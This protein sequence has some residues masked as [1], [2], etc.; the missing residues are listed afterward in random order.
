MFATGSCHR[1]A[2]WKVCRNGSLQN[3]TAEELVEACRPIEPVSSAFVS[4]VSSIWPINKI[5]WN[6]TQWHD[7]DETLAKIWLPFP[8]RFGFPAL[9]SATWNRLEFGPS[10]LPGTTRE[11]AT[12]GIV[13]KTQC[14]PALPGVDTWKKS[15]RKWTRYPPPYPLILIDVSMRHLFDT[16]ETKHIID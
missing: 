6:R 13:E 3:L 9:N 4:F 7:F 1:L 15:A 8:W 11:T 14:R 2:P 10:Q 16:S 12:S 5:F